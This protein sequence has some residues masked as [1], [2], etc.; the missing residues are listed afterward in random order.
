MSEAEMRRCIIDLVLWADEK[1]VRNIWG[2]VSN[3]LKDERVG[4]HAEPECI[5][6]HAD[7][8]KGKKKQER[9]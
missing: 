8:L 4:I 6:A 7:F 2:F 9:Q 1:K 3:Y 5:I